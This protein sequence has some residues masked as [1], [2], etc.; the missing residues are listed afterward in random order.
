[1]LSNGNW[2]HA[3]GKSNRLAMAEVSVICW[4]GICEVYAGALTQ[5]VSFWFLHSWRNHAHHNSV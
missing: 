3:G 1:M 5:E 4:D 2:I